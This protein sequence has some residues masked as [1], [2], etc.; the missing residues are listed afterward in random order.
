MSDTESNEKLNNEQPNEKLNNE[1][2][3]EDFEDIESR[4]REVI[5]LGKV[6]KSCV[7]N[8]ED[9]AETAFSSLMIRML[10]L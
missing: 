4:R 2:P 1:Q 10:S 5:E 6:H 9:L 3:N 7:F 8:V